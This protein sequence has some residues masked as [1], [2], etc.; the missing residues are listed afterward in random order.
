VKSGRLQGCVSALT[1][2]VLHFFRK[3]HRPDRAARQIVRTTLTHFEVIPLTAE[4]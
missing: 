3:R 1:S 2:A 4:S